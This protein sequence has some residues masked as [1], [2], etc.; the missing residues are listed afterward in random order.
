MSVLASAFLLGFSLP[1]PDSERWLPWGMRAGAA[2]ALLAV[3]LF[4]RAPLARPA[5]VIAVTVALCSLYANLSLLVTDPADYRFFPPFEPG[6]NLN[7]SHHLGAEYY[8]IA[9]ALASGRGFADP[10]RVPSGPTAWMPPVLPALLAAL[11]WASGDERD[12][13]TTVVLL[14]QNLTLL[15]SGVLVAALAH[16]TTGRT[17]LA[18]LLFLAVLLS[19]FQHSFQRTHDCWIVLAAID[20]LVAGL[21]WLRPLHSSWRMALGWGV[22]GGLCALTNPVV[23]FVWGLFGLADGWRRGQ[24]THLALALLAA[25]VTV[26][27]WVARNY[28]VFGRLL[29]IKSNLAFELYQSQ[30]VQPGGVLHVPIFSSHP[31]AGDNAERREYRRLGEMAYLDRKWDVFSEA[32]RDVPLDFGRRTIN[33]FLEVTLIYVPFNPAEESRRPWRV[34]CLKVLYPLP[35]LCLVGLLLRSVRRPLAPAQWVVIGVYVTYLLPYVLIG[36]YDRYKPPLMAVEAALL[37]WGAE[38]LFGW[39]SA[40]FAPLLRRGAD[41]VILRLLFCAL[42]TRNGKPVA[43]Q[44]FLSPS[45]SDLSAKPHAVIRGGC[46]RRWSSLACRHSSSTPPGLPF[47]TPITGFPARITS[48][49]STRR[50]WSVPRRTPGLGRRPRGGRAGSLSRRRCSSCGRREAFASPATTTAAPT[51]RRSGPIP[52]PVQSASRARATSARAPGR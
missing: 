8:S 40:F 39:L 2:L 29:P 51:T 33:R 42:D 19:Y 41:P 24:R 25:G 4:V 37:V 18:T 45:G 43:W 3:P 34:R 31:N 10:F 15:G 30:C 47:R 17:A 48:R 26:A 49:R 16:R 52:P 50:N 44:E 13:V 23:G 12:I 35:F 27:P 9:G 32:V 22:F 28:F 14:L 20:L 21:V 38:L 11:R 46:S 5:W 36:Y 7:E 1:S 6:R